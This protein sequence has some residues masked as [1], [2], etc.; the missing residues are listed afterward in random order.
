MASKRQRSI[1][2]VST[3]FFSAE[4]WRRI[5]EEVEEVRDDPSFRRDYAAASGKRDPHAGLEWL[6]TLA[7]D[8]RDSLAPLFIGEWID[9]SNEEA[10][11][12]LTGLPDSETEMIFR[13]LIFLRPGRSLMN[14]R[15]WSESEEVLYERLYPPSHISDL[16][17]RA[18]DWFD[19]VPVEKKFEL[20]SE[21][22]D[23]I[24]EIDPEE[25]LRWAVEAQS[26]VSED[27]PIEFTNSGRQA[28]DYVKTGFRRWME[29]DAEEA[30]SWLFEEAATEARDELIAQLRYGRPSNDEDADMPIYEWMNTISD[31]ELRMNSMRALASSE[32]TQSERHLESA[33]I[34]ESVR[35]DLQ[36]YL[37]SDNPFSGLE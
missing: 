10:I 36:E 16:R 29:G 7:A 13:S 34:P 25:V 4:L 17:S 19:S 9:S 8:E 3:H 5:Y 18:L 21:D 12:Y 22:P 15:L 26:A 6:E 32:G 31:P 23:T 24:L 28:S 20:I 14:Q 27:S 37:D 1:T 33:D 30:T 11:N 35:A 2:G